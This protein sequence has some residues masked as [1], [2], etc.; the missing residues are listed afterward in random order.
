MFRCP[1]CPATFDVLPD[2]CP[3]CGLS[4][5]VLGLQP[6]LAATGDGLVVLADFDSE[7]N[8]KIVQG[9]LAAEGVAVM[10][11]SSGLESIFGSNDPGTIAPFQ[12][13]VRREDATQR[14]GSSAPMLTGPKRSW[15]GI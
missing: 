15:R 13:L 10:L 1:A 12:L 7:M 3:E 9:R 4:L 2:I 8:A 14:C 6:I 11:G 5:K